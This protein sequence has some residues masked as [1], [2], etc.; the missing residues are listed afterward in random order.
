[1]LV[2]EKGIDGKQQSFFYLS[3][4]EIDYTIILSF[5]KVISLC[6]TSR[7]KGIDGTRRSFI[8]LADRYIYVS[9]FK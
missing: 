1:M 3:C 9:F 7:R 2:E 8:S 5:L 6:H 4:I